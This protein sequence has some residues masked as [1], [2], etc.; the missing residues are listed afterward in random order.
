M[1]EINR[2][3]YAIELG[4]KCNPETGEIITHKSK[5]LK[6]NKKGYILCSINVNSEIFSFKGHRFVWFVRYS[7]L[8]ENHIDHINGIRDDNRISNLRDVTQQQNNHNQTKA[9]GYC[10]DKK[11]KKWKATI[12][13]NYKKIHLGY[14]DNENDARQAYLNAKKIYHKF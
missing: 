3:Q 14:F 1:N 7:K 13:L 10:W 11:L 2:M 4:W 9:K 5:I 6:A 12:V 8:P